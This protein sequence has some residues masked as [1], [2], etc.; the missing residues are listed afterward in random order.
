MS[1]IW[2]KLYTEALHDRKMRKLSR[3][4]KSV[5]YDLLLLAGQEDI[6]GALPPIDD[7]A[8]ELDLNVSEAQKSVATLK[9]AGLLSDDNG[10]LYVTS[11]KT[12]Q[13]SNLTSA[14]KV[15]RFRSNHKADNKKV[16]DVTESGYM[17]N[18]DVTEQGYMRNPDV[19]QGR[20]TSNGNVTKSGYNGN[21]DVTKAGYKSEKNVTSE[22]D[23][24]I[25]KD[26]KGVTN[27]TPYG[28]GAS[29]APIDWHRAFGAEADRAKAFSDASG[30]IPIN[31]EYGRW[32]NDLRDFT[33]A[34]I[35]IPQMVEAI[36]KI[37]REGKYPIKA[38]GTVLTEARNIAAK[39]QPQS[40]DD[41]PDAYT[42]MKTLAEHPEIIDL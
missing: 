35:S 39:P 11:F 28:G 29:A 41:F 20:Y 16:T 26:I 15:A 10:T 40:I 22:L 42:A 17:C 1:K 13:E 9:S 14:E 38:P 32:Q 31:K 24:D 25:E 8:L 3:F 36:R 34:G 12:R 7:I 21:H 4:D 6:D 27:V 2:I 5:F 33:K 37:R 19:T 18:G 23:I 30:I